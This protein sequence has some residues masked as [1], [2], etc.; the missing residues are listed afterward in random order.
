MFT[1]D[2]Q[3]FLRDLEANNNKT[4]F[5]A[6]KARFQ[7]SVQEPALAFV[8]EAA[9]WLDAAGLPYRGEAKKSGGALSRIYRDTR[10]SN[11][12]TPYHTH[13]VIHFGHKDGSRDKL[14]PVIGIRFNAQEVGLGGG[15]YGGQTKDLNKVRDA[16]IASPEAWQQ[17]TIKQNLW[18]DSLKTAPK[19]YDKDHPL[20]EDIRRKQFMVSANL[21]PAQFQ[22]DLMGA[23]QAGTQDIMP[24]L[25][26]LADA[27]D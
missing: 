13:M 2:A 23:F 19:G 20:I 9:D 25:D 21:T 18:G 24:F 12:K 16:I 17:A 4:W 11:D 10:F 6:N 26:F 3:Q 15:I 8:R 27:L 5:E 1:S 14:M 22:G 7:Q